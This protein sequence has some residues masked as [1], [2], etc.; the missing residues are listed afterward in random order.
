MYLKQNNKLLAFAG[1]GLITL[2]FPCHAQVDDLATRETVNLY[3]NMKRLAPDKMMYGQHQAYF[4]GLYADGLG[5]MSDCKVICGSNPAV[6][7]YDFNQDSQWSPTNSAMGFN[8][9]AVAHFRRNGINTFSWHSRNPSPEANDGGGYRDMTGNPVRGILDP[10]SP[11]HANFN[12]MLEDISTFFKNLKTEEGTWIPVIWRPFH[13]NSGDWFWWGV[14]TCSPAEYKQL[15][16]YTYNYLTHTQGVHNLL[17]AYSP[18]RPNSEEEYLERYPGDDVVDIIGFDR[19]GDADGDAGFVDDMRA[20]I[21]TV[22]TLAQERGK[23]AA[24]TESGEQKG[25]E[26]TEWTNWITRVW[27]EP[28]QENR[29]GI[30]YVMTWSSTGWTAFKDGPNA[31]LHD[32][33]MQFYRSQFTVFENDLPN[34]YQ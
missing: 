25:F 23:L 28:V 29:G 15:W 30:A 27:L 14:S 18:S 21:R 32:D 34:M 2:L 31:H 33:F 4:T 13:E 24:I 26:N 17:W 7:G 5:Q 1:T 20:S 19:Y 12:R 16:H 8:K 11:A 10:A 9:Q 22:T 3:R 6:V